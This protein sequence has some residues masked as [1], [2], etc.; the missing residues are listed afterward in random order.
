[1]FWSVDDLPHP[2]ARWYPMPC[3]QTPARLD[4]HDR[5]LAA[6]VVSDTAATSDGLVDRVATLEQSMQSRLQ[7][8]EIQDAQTDAGRRR[9]VEAISHFHDMALAASQRSSDVNDSD[10]CSPGL[11]AS[12]DVEPCADVKEEE[13]ETAGPAGFCDQ[14][15]CASMK[16][17]CFRRRLVPGCTVMIGGLTAEG[18]TVDEI[19]A[20]FSPLKVKIDTAADTASIS[21]DTA[22]QATGFAKEIMGQFADDGATTLSVV[23]C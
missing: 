13:L 14:L 20:S 23:I 6:L 4:A 17:Y 5:V 1:M 3:D 2:V 22:L 15:K 11:A 8:E 16:R 18:S 21:F 19:R 9:M 10:D 12:C 7:H